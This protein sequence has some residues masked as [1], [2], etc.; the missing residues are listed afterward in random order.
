MISSDTRVHSEKSKASGEWLGQHAVWLATMLWLA[1][2]AVKA[3][4]VA[5]MNPQT[6]L[7]I[8]GSPEALSVAFFVLLTAIPTVFGALGFVAFYWGFGVSEDRSAVESVAAASVYLLAL[9]FIAVIAPLATTILLVAL[10]VAALAFHIR[11]KRR[12]EAPRIDDPAV[13]EV[14]ATIETAEALLA[15]LAEIGEIT[16]SSDLAR[17][18][19]LNRRMSDV[20]RRLTAANDLVKTHELPQRQTRFRTSFT[21]KVFLVAMV[22]LQVITLSMPLL[23]SEPWL[24][25]ERLDTPSGQRVGYVMG[26]G[27]GEWVTLLAEDS[28]RIS[29]LRAADL[30]SRGICQTRSPNF[31]LSLTASDVMLSKRAPEYPPCDPKSD[32][33][34]D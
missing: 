4:R 10:P 9:A 24:P 30:A 17:V 5:N 28:R 22:G 25:P 18:E 3:L 11:D 16:A 32:G 15:E 14:K 2:V 19:D 8:L 6:A 27:D 23:S 31:W 21:P 20:T 1:L 33:N 34:L 13:V 12:R 26:E 7:A 29:R